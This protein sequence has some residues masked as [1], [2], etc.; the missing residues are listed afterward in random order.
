[1]CEPLKKLRLK[2]PVLLLQLSRV[3]LATDHIHCF[4]LIGTSW[5]CTHQPSRCIK[6]LCPMTALHTVVLCFTV[7]SEAK[8][9]RGNSSKPPICCYLLKMKI[10]TQ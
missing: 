8:S 4:I 10:A 3:V 5:L 2:Y 7:I 9:V 6:Q 1:M